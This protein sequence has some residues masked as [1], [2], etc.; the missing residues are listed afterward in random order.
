MCSSSRGQK[1][2]YTASGIVTLCR[3]PAGAQVETG[4]QSSLSLCTGQYNYLTPNTFKCLQGITFLVYFLRSF[5][6]WGRTTWAFCCS[7]SSKKNKK[8]KIGEL[9]V[10]R[11]PC[12][13]KTGL[14][15]HKNVPLTGWRTSYILNTLCIQNASSACIWVV[16]PVLH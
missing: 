6:T 16:I 9:T 12:Q 13:T 5:W 8:K 14:H 2:Y 3:W 7:I 1:L 15:S 10:V 4:L 11:C